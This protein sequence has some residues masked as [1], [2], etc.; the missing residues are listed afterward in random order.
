M[1]VIVLRA[2]GSLF[3]A[4]AFPTTGADLRSFIDVAA[5]QAEDKEGDDE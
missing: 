4:T 3:A 1:T 2:E 5:E